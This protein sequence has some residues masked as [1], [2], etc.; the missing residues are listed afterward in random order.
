MHNTGIALEMLRAGPTQTAIAVQSAV[1]DAL[2]NITALG[3]RD[4]V[5]TVETIEN[6]QK[7]SKI[8]I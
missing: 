2:P 5:E 7:E 3:T 4:I 6:N 8:F 1:V